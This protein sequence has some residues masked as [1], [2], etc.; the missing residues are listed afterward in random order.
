MLVG[1]LGLMG[2]PIITNGGYSKEMIITAAYEAA[3]HGAT[4]HWFTFIVGVLVA[5]LTTLYAARMF[6]MIFHGKNRGAHI[7]KPKY[8][9]RIVLGILAVGVVATGFLIEGPVSNFFTGDTGYKLIH[10]ELVPFLSAIGAIILG[11]GLAFL[12]YGKG[13]TE[14]GFVENISVFKAL[15]T[16][17][18]NGFYIDHFYNKVFVAPVFWIGKKLSFFKTGKINWN[19][20]FGGV[21][22]VLV[23]VITLVVVIV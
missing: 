8:I 16:Y 4:M 10:I 15:R 3:T 23:V 21:V 11:L 7:H 22:A 2:I 1:V 6:L 14:V 9:M 20:I 12:L 13:Q 18:A 5:F 19:M 17:V